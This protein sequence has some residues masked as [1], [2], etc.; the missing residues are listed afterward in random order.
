MLRHVIA[1]S[2]IVLV[3]SGFATSDRGVVFEIEVTLTGVMTHPWFGFSTQE[4][5]SIVSGARTRSID[6]GTLE[7]RLRF[8]GSDEELQ[9]AMV[10]G[11]QVRLRVDC[12][13]LK[14]EEVPARAGLEARRGGHDAVVQW[15]K[16][17]TRLERVCG[18]R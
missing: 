12:D 3:T 7:G 4:P 8:K 9:A 6:V 14:E 5:V 10:R 13:H 15:D 18:A 17:F 1:A 11:T 2:A 16:E